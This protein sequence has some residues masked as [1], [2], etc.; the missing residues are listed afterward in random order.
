MKLVL[1]NQKVQLALGAIILGLGLSTVGHVELGLS[2]IIAGVGYIKG[3]LEM[4]PA[5]EKMLD[6]GVSE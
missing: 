2:L 5:T 4:R 3:K 1:G 6:E